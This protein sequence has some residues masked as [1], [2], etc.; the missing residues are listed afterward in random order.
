MT[1]SRLIKLAS[2]AALAMATILSATAHADPAKPNVLLR[3]LEESTGVRR[4][5]SVHCR[6]QD[7]HS[8]V[9][10]DA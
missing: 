8:V 2:I 10:D 9:A 1:L 5:E 6:K 7:G 4:L 3:G